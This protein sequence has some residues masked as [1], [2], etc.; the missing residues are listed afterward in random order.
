MEDVA[1]TWGESWV[2][3]TSEC[4]GLPE[5]DGVCLG[6]GV[7]ALSARGVATLSEPKFTHS[8][9]TQV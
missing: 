8:S 7:D 5:R 9:N 1:L 2:A 4:P 6:F 3:F